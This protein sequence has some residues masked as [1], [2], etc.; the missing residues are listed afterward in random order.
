HTTGG[1]QMMREAVKTVDDFCNKKRLKK[2]PL[3]LGVTVLTSLDEKSLALVSGYK[4]PLPVTGRV[5]AL[6][7]LAQK[8]GLDGVVASA[9]EVPEIK[10]ACGK[11][12]ITVCPGIRL[13]EETPI[14]GIND[15][16]RVITP[17]EAAK[18]GADYIVLGRPIIQALDPVSVIESVRK[19][20][21]TKK[22][23]T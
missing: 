3:I 18:R 17:N 5:V 15:Q 14:T 16:A 19:A 2:R 22:T 23:K 11:D 7:K 6:A 8:A 4:K 1:L 21:E 10:K 13:P 9:R 12:F 20:L